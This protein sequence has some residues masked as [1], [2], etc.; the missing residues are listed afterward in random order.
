MNSESPSVVIGRRIRYW[1]MGQHLTQEQLALMSGTSK[2]HIWRIEKAKV[3]ARAETLARI[4]AA[5]GVGLRDLI[6]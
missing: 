1:R 4:A 6:A 3:S 5:L 2:A